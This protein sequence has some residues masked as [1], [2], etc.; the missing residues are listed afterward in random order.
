MIAEAIPKLATY[1][2]LLA[3]ASTLP[4]G[5]RL[6]LVLALSKQ[7]IPSEQVQLIMQI[8]PDVAPTINAVLR[9]KTAY[10]IEGKAPTDVHSLLA[11]WLAE[12]VFDE[13]EESWDEIMRNLD[14]YP[15]HDPIS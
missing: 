11:T 4:P 15:E 6:K 14:A 9:N 12:P 1:E 3:V 2:N 8:L 7:L 13:D 10:V 5:E